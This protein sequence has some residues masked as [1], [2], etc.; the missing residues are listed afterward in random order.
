MLII[1]E[2]LVYI[3]FG[4]NSLKKIETFENQVLV[5]LETLTEA[6]NKLIAS[7]T[8]M[9]LLINKILKENDSS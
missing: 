7:Q 5:A 1:T 9:I 8:L 3:S 4:F 6:V 2:I